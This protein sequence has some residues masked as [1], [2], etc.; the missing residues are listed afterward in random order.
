MI[1]ATAFCMLAFV[2]QSVP[3]ESWATDVTVR[4]AT[5]KTELRQ[6]PARNGWTFRAGHKLRARMDNERQIITI[7]GDHALS[8]CQYG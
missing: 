6:Y 4:S 2:G 3:V 5:G 1:G 8:V 7:T